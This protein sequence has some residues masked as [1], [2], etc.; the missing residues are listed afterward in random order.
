MF[1]TGFRRVS[2]VV[3]AIIIGIVAASALPAGSSPATTVSRDALVPPPAES[4][5]EAKAKAPYKIKE[6]SWLPEGVVMEHA[7]YSE[8][9]AFSVGMWYRDAAGNRVL[10]IWQTNMSPEALSAKDPADP[11]RG[12]PESV[13]G[14]TWRREAA[15]RHGYS[16]DILSRRF[17]DGTTVTV[18]ASDAAIN[19]GQLKKIAES[20]G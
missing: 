18:D 5:A 9:G 1:A 11:R 12:V 13:G 17:E 8:E 7:Q 6:P 3:G 20:V 16:L 10:H 14:K 19:Y 2:A 15:P 4:M